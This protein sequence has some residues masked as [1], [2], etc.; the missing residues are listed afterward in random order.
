MVCAHAQLVINRLRAGPWLLVPAGF[1]G[2][3]PQAVRPTGEHIF[4]SKHCMTQ[5]PAPLRTPSLFEDTC[6]R[7]LGYRSVLPSRLSVHSCPLREYLRR[8]RRTDCS[9]A[10]TRREMTRYDKTTIERLS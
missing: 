6:A 9:V 7:G 4:S 1:L 3:H 5:G 10:V 8:S 2:P